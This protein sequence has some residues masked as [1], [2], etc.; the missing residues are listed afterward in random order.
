VTV[1]R[2]GD[3]VLLSFASCKD[4]QLCKQGHAPHCLRF[5]DINFGCL[6]NT[7]ETLAHDGRDHE[8]TPVAGGFFGQSSFARLSIV[9][10]CS[11]VNVKD[12]I[13]NKQELELY[14]PLGC[15]IQTGSGTVVN[16]AKLGPADVLC[17]TGLGGVGLSA[18]MAAKMQ[19]CKTIIGIDRVQSRLDLAKDLGATATI[20]TGETSLGTLVDTVRQLAD[21]IGPTV[22]IETTGVPAVIK[23]AL[24][25]T[26]PMGKIIQ[27]RAAPFDFTIEIGVFDW[28]VQGKQFIGAVE[29]HAKPSTFIPQL[30]AWHKQ[31]K[32]PIERFIKKFDAVDF[33]TA[34]EE[35]STGTTVKPV[36]CWSLGK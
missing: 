17:V 4:C 30:I 5:N 9:K 10:E 34:V 23:D 29:G 32:F 35:M 20:H 26:R 24:T 7:F 19:G 22:C 31:G 36:L 21:G 25:F 8:A 27:V 28:M 3:P 16:V 15:G 13:S 2:S 12:L 1:A 6:D 11:V 33:R 18:I 14:A